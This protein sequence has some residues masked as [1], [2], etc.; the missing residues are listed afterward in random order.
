[1][2][3]Y[4][5]VVAELESRDLIVP[6]WGQGVKARC[7]A[8]DDDRPSLS[9]SRGDDGKALVYCHAGCN[10]QDI[11]DALDLQMTDLFKG[12]HD[13]TIVGAYVYTDEAGA[14]LFRVLRSSD[15]DF[16]QQ[17]WEDGEWKDG[18]R[19]TRRVLYE[20][21]RLRKAIQSRTEVFLVEG[22]KDANNLIDLGYTAT[23]VPGGAGSWN[24]TYLS[25][26]R[27]GHDI[28]IIADNDTPGLAAAHRA[29]SALVSDGVDR[30]A[31]YL[32]KEGK[33]VTD[34]LRAGY[35]IDELELV[36]NGGDWDD[37][38][39]DT[40]DIEWLVEPVLGRGT[41]VWAYGSKETAKSMYL[42]ALAAELSHAGN[43]STYYSEEMAKNLDRR[44]IARFAP[45][46]QYFRW[47]NGRGLNLADEEQ[48]EQVI[49]ENA[50][51]SLIIFD[52]YE[53]VWNE[54]KAK[55]ENRRAVACAAAL[56]RITNETGAT[57]VI[58]DHT[59]FPFR[60]SEGN[61]HEE[62]RPRGAS[63]KEQ[64]A[65][66]AILFTTKGGWVKGQPFRFKIENMKPGRLENPFKYELE[67]VD[68]A[69]GGLAVVESNQ[70]ESE[71]IAEALG[72]SSP[73]PSPQDTPENASESLRTPGMTL[74]EKLAQAREEAQ[75]VKA[76]KRNLG[77]TLLEVEH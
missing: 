15:K 61:L 74:S 36:G 43:I 65:D 73:S 48:L 26:L 75:A 35:T 9:V 2:E 77:A 5:K 70:G 24:D 8:H 71:R 55:S 51:S 72:I 1:M 41:V 13:A 49:T 58:I 34:H 37:W 12:K 69:G 66:M 40:P 59:G 42:L 17:R 20:L 11:V 53:K 39:E 50:N 19:D 64:Q 54:D 46:K 56:R 10:V 22:E 18:L 67:V 23:T 21:P 44:R 16:W 52:S 3:G 7:P 31:V 33:D 62:R 38:D 6:S 29:H 68:T 30:V 63:S 60:D 4:E 25:S 27:D 45:N 57:V 76:I 14:P 28:R 47:K 32:P